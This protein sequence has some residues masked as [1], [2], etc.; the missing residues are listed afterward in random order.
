M[1]EKL[2]PCPLCG[3]TD[4]EDDGYCINCNKCPVAL[5]ADAKTWNA[6]PRRLTWSPEVPAH[7]GWYWVKRKVDGTLCLINVK[8]D[9]VQ[10]PAGVYAGPIT[11]PV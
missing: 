6:L 8:K 4:I 10:F 5:M 3:S 1:S 2:K 11:E 7:E 9:T